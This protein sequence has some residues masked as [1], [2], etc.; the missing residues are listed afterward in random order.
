MS[1]G[2]IEEN[3]SPE[4]AHMLAEL[5][6]ELADRL[7]QSTE[8][9]MKGQPLSREELEQLAKLVGLNN[10]QDLRYQNWMAQRMERALAFPE[11]REAL[12]QLM[13]Q[14]Q[15]IERFNPIRVPVMRRDGNIDLLAEG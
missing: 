6:R 13:E 14:L 11:V 12:Q 7:R 3:L 9:L 15:Q 5:L 2:D 1:A 4:E 8:R 10:T